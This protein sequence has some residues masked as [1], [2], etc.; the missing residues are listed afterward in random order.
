M[1]GAAGTSK[2]STGCKARPPFTL[3]RLPY[4]PG[5]ALPCCI[6]R[7]YGT[8]E[9]THTQLTLLFCVIRV[10]NVRTIS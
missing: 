1:M 7:L 2:G 5:A 9:R 4:R 10:I 6:A 3:A 8:H